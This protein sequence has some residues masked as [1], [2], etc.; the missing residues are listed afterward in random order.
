MTFQDQYMRE[1]FPEPPL[2]A[3]RRQKN[4]RDLLIR[5]RVPGPPRPHE[6][7]VKRGMSR[8]GAQCT[9]YPYVKC[10]KQIRISENSY[11]HINREVNC[12]SFNV[13]YLIECDKQ[14]CTMKYI[15][16]TG[17]V[18]KFRL[19]EHRGYISTKDETQAT[20]AHFNLPGHSLANMKA[21]IIEQVK[22]NDHLYIK[23]REHFYI[24]KLNT[25]YQGL[26]NQK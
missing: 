7:R 8:C 12:T 23:E 6:Q 4:L 10:V 19:D 11:W 25:F 5:A 14:N 2:T 26:N 24:R 20:S 1:V 21:T 18:F 16:E 9:A 17:R 22:V 13:V 3:F 15:G